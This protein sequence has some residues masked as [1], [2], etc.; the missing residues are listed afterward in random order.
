VCFQSIIPSKN[1]RQN[2]YTRKQGAAAAIAHY[3]FCGIVLIHVQKDIAGCA[4]NS[5]SSKKMTIN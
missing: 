4:H 2:F 3:S 5:N 1:G